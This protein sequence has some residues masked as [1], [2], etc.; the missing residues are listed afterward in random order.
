VQVYLSDVVTSA[1]WAD[2]ELKA[3]RQVQ[4]APGESATVGLELPAG[5]CTIVDRH[6]ARV[7]EPGEFA[8]LVGP[9]SRDEALLR[10]TFAVKG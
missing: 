4:L 1:T 5:D 3:Y 9:S 10:A 2:K 8:L 6:G 7:V